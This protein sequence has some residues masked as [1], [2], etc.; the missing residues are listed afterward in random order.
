MRTKPLTYKQAGVD[1]AGAEKFVKKIKK[2]TR[3]TITP[4]SKSE[5]G[6]F[7]AIFDFSGLK[8]KEPLLI[9]STDGVGTKLKIAFLTNRHDTVGIDLVAMNVNDILTTGATPLFFLD[10]ISTSK[11]KVKVLT[12][13]IK[14]ISRGC[15][16]AGCSLIGGELAE[17]PGFYKRGE[18]DLAGFCTGVVEKKKMLAGE[19][20][21]QGD[22]VIGLAS[23]GLHSNGFSLVREVFSPKEQRNLAGELLKPTSIYVK[24]VISLLKKVNSRSQ[25]AI[26]AMAHVTGGA[27]YQKVSKILPQGRAIN[28]YKDTW[29]VPGIFRLIEKKGHIK[30]K[31]MFGTFNMGIGFVLIAAAKDASKI[32]RY[33]AIQKVKSW[34]I[35]EVV[36]GKREIRIS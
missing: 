3:A 30:E 20:V 21:S 25:K 22:V 13:I 23:S 32:I 4:K 2:F 10:Y 34:V 26:K 29:P 19:N 12:D 31:E 7:G 33:L 1:I 11:I 24:P 15:R 35:G 27:F 5:I 8:V 14:G 16:D 9:S 17:M 28:I 6:G 36:K 18:Y